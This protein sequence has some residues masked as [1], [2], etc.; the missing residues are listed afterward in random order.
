MSLLLTPIYSIFGNT[1]N[2]GTDPQHDGPLPEDG[3]QDIE[4]FKTAVEQPQQHVDD[5]LAA[6]LKQL[7]S[8]LGE[9][10]QKLQK[11]QQEYDA[12]KN[13]L[14]KKSATEADVR[15]IW[16]KTAKELNKLRVNSQGFY[17]ITDE[18]LIEQINY[19]K[20]SIRDFSIQYFD[21]RSVP[22]GVMPETLPDYWGH[23]KDSAPDRDPSR[24]L[25][26]PKNCHKLIQAFLWR[27]IIKK[28]FFTFEWLGKDCGD[29]FYEVWLA[30]LPCKYG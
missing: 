1:T 9:R 10:D 8:E 27:F 25:M 18:Y 2:A 7:E 13:E 3:K 23:L 5:A 12:L 24:Y 26:S 28:L 11:L 30:L 6:R 22:K 16:K 29:D 19:L 17:Q 21:G 20:I 15:K 4:N 14:D